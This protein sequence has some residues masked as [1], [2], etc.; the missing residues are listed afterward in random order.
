MKYTD[1]PLSVYQTPYEVITLHKK[2]GG[3]IQFTNKELEW[4]FANGVVYIHS[5][6]TLYEIRHSVNAGYSLYPMC[7]LTVHT[8]RGR[9]FAYTAEEVN[10]SLQDWGAPILNEN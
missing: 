4:M 1:R 6:L 5:G 3:V 8:M 2:H 10:R 7:N 9:Y